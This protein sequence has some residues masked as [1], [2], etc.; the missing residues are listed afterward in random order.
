M[1]KKKVFSITSDENQANL[2]SVLKVKG[3]ELN[4]INVLNF[5]EWLLRK[6][7]VKDFIKLGPLERIND[8]LATSFLE[9]LRIANRQ[10]PRDIFN[11]I[12]AQEVSGNMTN[13]K[14]ALGYDGEWRDIT[15][16]NV[17]MVRQHVYFNTTFSSLPN[18]TPS[19]FKFPISTNETITT[20][21]KSV[22]HDIENIKYLRMSTIL[23]PNSLNVSMIG[24]IV[25]MNIREFSN[26][27]DRDYPN[28]EHAYEF[29]VSFYG[30]RLSLTPLTPTFFF[31]KYVS[32]LDHFTFSFYVQNAQL[33]FQSPSTSAVLTFGASPSLMTTTIPHGLVTGDLV[34]FYDQ[35]AFPLVPPTSTQLSQLNTTF[36]VLVVDATEFTIPVNLT[37]LT[38]STPIVYYTLKNIIEFSC[39]F[40][41]L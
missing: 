38:G 4:D 10:T 31:P 39:E 12:K 29:N 5:T 34:S 1:Q 6:D 8:A 24:Q 3:Y 11:T 18:S 19:V 13:P 36:Q 26:L 16:D 21:Y 41:C 37:A 23:A 9:S 2:L 27:S 30:S 17:N 35:G 32:L 20:T 28:I 40:I 15:L 14:L 22:S 25:K 33:E 7:N